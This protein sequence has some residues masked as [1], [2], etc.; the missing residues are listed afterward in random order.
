[1]L[2]SMCKS[3]YDDPTKMVVIDMRDTGSKPLNVKKLLNMVSKKIHGLKNIKV[4][5]LRKWSEIKRKTHDT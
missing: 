3:V 4:K 5:K 1:M 2:K